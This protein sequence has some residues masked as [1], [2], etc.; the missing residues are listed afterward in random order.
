MVLR[1][2]LFT[3]YLLSELLSS[4]QQKSALAANPATIL[5]S[6]LVMANS[7]KAAT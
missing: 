6:P 5:L 4:P 7:N 1:Q 3:S 2:T